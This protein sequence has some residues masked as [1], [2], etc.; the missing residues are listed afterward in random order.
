MDVTQVDFYDNKIGKCEKIRAHKEGILHRAFSIFIFNSKN[1]LLLQK[2]ALSKYHSPGKWSNS[3]CSHPIT[4][5]IKEEAKARLLKEMGVKCELKEIFSFQYK[6][7]VETLIEN[8]FDH[9]FI[10]KS[11]KTPVPDKKEVSDWRFISIEDLN[12]EIKK[13]PELFTPWLRLSID[14]VSKNALS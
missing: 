2:R 11:D 1:E 9:V 14:E 10:G 6:A 4:D 13:N 7:K 12:N 8:E 3:C 5:D